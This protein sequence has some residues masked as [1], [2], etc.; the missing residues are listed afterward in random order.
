MGRQ[1]AYDFAK[2]GAT[3]V[4][5]AR[6]EEHLAEL[7]AQVETDGLLGTI[8]YER[9]ASLFGQRQAKSARGQAHSLL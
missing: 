3:V 6:R 5:V 9:M 1:I 2:E 8:L 7:A 4:A